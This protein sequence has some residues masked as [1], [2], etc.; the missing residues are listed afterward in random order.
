MLFSEFS[1]Q[2]T[3]FYLGCWV[4][5]FVVPHKGS[6]GMSFLCSKT[7]EFGSLKAHNVKLHHPSGFHPHPPRWPGCCF[8][9][10][11]SPLSQLA[12]Q[13][14]V[15]ILVPPLCNLFFSVISFPVDQGLVRLFLFWPPPHPRRLRSMFPVDQGLPIFS[16][17][18]PPRSTYDVPFCRDF[19]G[20]V[21]S[22]T[23]IDV[24]KRKKTVYTNLSLNQYFKID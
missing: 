10:T 5:A 12:E 2:I 15:P 11:K 17:T 23:K 9:P 19:F 8:C 4:P 24:L 16:A 14:R 1:L 18:T 20:V 7:P 6:L 22:P 21:G 3:D 13:S